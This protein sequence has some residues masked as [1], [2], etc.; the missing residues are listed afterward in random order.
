MKDKS[1]LYIEDNFHNRRLVQKIL[2]AKGYQVELAEDGPS[3]W[4]LI[5]K[6]KPPLVL[7][8][9]GL[10]GMDGL[11]IVRRTKSDPELKDTWV[12]ALTAAAMQ[13]D[14]DRFL[15]AGCDD[16]VPKPIQVKALLQSVNK[17]FQKQHL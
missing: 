17:F 6:L 7:L 13:G 1:V 5:Q 10:P 11:E 8:D 16:Y 12:V 4:Q 2:Q 15:E 3:G 14:R 9:I